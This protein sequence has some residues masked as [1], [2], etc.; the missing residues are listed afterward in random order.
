VTVGTPP[1]PASLLIDTGSSDFWLPAPNSSGCLPLPCPPGS[2][3]YT[4]SSTFS[5]TS[6]TYNG[7]FGL[8]PDNQLIGQYF[9]DTV[10][11]GT[12][13][14]PDMTMAVVNVTKTLFFDGF[15]GIIGLGAR[16]GEST[17]VNPSSPFFG[18][19]NG[20]FPT[21]YDQLQAHGYTA[22]R[23]FSIWLNSISARTGRIIFGGIDITKYHGPLVSVPVQLTQGHFFAWA[24][25]LTSVACCDAGT[26]EDLTAP[27]YNATVVLD[28]GTPNKLPALD[29]GARH[30]L[31][32]E[33][34]D[35]RRDA[36][37][38]LRR[39]QIPTPRLISGL[40]LRLGPES[41]SPIPS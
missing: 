5:A 10:H 34:Y 37:R 32:H 21:L 40:A 26:K 20:T 30:R 2:Y 28:S 7:T 3:D 29:S 35:A 9:H 27:D 38:A 13:T 41:T 6:V 23:T 18:N 22:R 1:Q 19:P 15:W 16:L 25:A 12:A 39:P 31:S 36:L 4:K 8:T 33:R 11:I 17:F 14:I 24:V